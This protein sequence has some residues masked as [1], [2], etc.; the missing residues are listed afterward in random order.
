MEICQSR[1]PSSTYQTCINIFKVRS[2][3]MLN[4]L[5]SNY[6]TSRIYD[7]LSQAWVRLKKK[8]K[9]KE[10]FIS[11][12]HLTFGCESHHTMIICPYKEVSFGPHEVDQCCCEVRVNNSVKEICHTFSSL[13]FRSG[14]AVYWA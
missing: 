8:E 14:L 12:S 11:T 1:L 13:I 4:Y 5:N 9:K 10:K 7:K 2:P 6:S 3:C